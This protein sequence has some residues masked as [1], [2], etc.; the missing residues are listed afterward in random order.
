MLASVRPDDRPYYRHVI[1]IRREL[2]GAP[3]RQ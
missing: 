3:R 1:A 2:V